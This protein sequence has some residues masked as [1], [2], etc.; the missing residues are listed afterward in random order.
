MSSKT[1][2]STKSTET[3]PRLGGLSLGVKVVLVV[4]L[5]VVALAG[6]FIFNNPK[7]GSGQAGQ[8]PYQVGLPDSGDEAPA[9]R[10]PSTK[11]DIF[12]LVAL[13]G[14]TVLLFFQEG[15]MCQPCW[16]QLKDIETR[17]KEFQGLG[18]DRMV[19]ITTDPLGALKQKVALEGLSTV[20]LSDPSLSVSQVY[21]TN[22]YGMMGNSRNGHSFILVGK[23]GKIRWRADYGGAPKYTMYVPVPNLLADLK[24]GLEGSARP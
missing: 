17:W 20:M 10:L 11:G 24:Q 14:Q 1:H 21:T 4:G 16:I 22:N 13:R 9:I 8:Y 3:K 6:I 7:P 19:S 15:L 23:D 5:A 18:V 2:K 12:E